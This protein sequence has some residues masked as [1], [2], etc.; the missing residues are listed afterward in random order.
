[1]GA[2]MARRLKDCGET[3]TAVHDISAE[4]ARAL[5][6]E[7]GCRAVPTLAGVTQAADVIFTVVSDDAAMRRIFALPSRSDSLL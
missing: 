6:V 2:N 7:L 1:M 3:I 5:A 4:T